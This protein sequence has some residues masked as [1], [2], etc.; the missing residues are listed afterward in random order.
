[1]SRRRRRSEDT[2]GS[3]GPRP[4]SLAL[5]LFGTALLWLFLGPVQLGGD[6][7]YSVI[8]GN[9]MEPLLH[10]GDLAAVRGDES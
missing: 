3:S 5:I 7:A 2:S 9:S 4:L 8:S 6:T 1:M 10:R